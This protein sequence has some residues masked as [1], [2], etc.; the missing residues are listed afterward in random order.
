MKARTKA[1]RLRRKRGRPKLEAEAREPNGR[2]SRRIASQH[3]RE[4]ENLNENPNIQRRIR[5][6]NIIPFRRPDGKIVTE[7]EQARDGRRGYLLGRLLLDGVINSVQHE[8]GVKFAE[9][10]SRYYGLYGLP[11]PSAR[12][13]NLFAVHGHD[14]GQDRGAEAQ[15]LKER[16][17]KQQDM[18]LNTGNIDT[19]RRI[20]HTV[21]LVCVED[22]PSQANLPKH[23]IDW[24]RRGLNQL[25]IYYGMEAIKDG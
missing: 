25:G 2:H 3:K 21:N 17:R 20:W 1:E 14:S 10:M 22:L 7:V 16:R 5:E 9:D 13:Q 6:G 15:H 19:G 4:A 23:M 18:L 24:L 8:A 11:F 12:A